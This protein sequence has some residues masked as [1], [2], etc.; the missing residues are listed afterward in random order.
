MRLMIIK[1]PGKLKKLEPMMKK[2][3]PGEHW[4]VVATVGH[5]RDR[6]EKGQDETM[7]TTGVLKNFPAR[8]RDAPQERSQRKHD[9]Q[10]AEGCDRG[11]HCD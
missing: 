2:S 1:A 9:P 6:P 8:I 11:L 10:G 4:T 3:R 7:I 5:I